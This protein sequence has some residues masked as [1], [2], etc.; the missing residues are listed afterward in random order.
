MLDPGRLRHRITIERPVHTQNSTTGEI[1]T[2]W[3]AVVENEP[4]AVEPL[5][6]REFIAAQSVQSAVTLRV[7]IRYRPGLTADMRVI[8][9]DRVYDP[10]GW[11]PDPDSGIEYLTAPCSSA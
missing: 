4:A 10:Q 9:G 6:V 8:H 3:E 7:V 1:T 2:T 5:S 11:L